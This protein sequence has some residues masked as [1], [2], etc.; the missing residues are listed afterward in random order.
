MYAYFFNQTQSCCRC[1]NWAA[2]ACL[3]YTLNIIAVNDLATQEA[4]ASLPGS[5]RT[6]HQQGEAT[7][8]NTPFR[9]TTITWLNI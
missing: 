3:F 4:A 1:L 5:F 8:L 9:I 7:L 2:R 6:Q